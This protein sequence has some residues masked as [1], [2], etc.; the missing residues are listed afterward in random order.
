VKL[1]IYIAGKGFTNKAVSQVIAALLLIAISVAA[2]VLVYVFSIG[3]LGSLQSSGGQQAKQQ[4]IMEAYNWPATAGG[5]GTALSLTV[6]NVGPASVQFADLFINGVASTP[7]SWSTPTIL[8]VGQST[9]IAVSP[10]GTY[11]AGTSYVIKIVTIDGAVF[12]YSAIY[13]QSS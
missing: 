3:L 5:T 1:V 11:N 13:G 7:S 6:R 10:S 2:A 8:A 9:T 4:V 12:S